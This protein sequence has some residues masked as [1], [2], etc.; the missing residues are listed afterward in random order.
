MYKV[1][2]TV[3]E[4]TEEERK[5]I[6]EEIMAALINSWNNTRKREKENEK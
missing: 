2:E 3:M 1:T 4:T 5:K 6:D